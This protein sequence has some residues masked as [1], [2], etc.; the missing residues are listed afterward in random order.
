[1]LMGWD[2]TKETLSKRSGLE[3]GALGSRW[4]PAVAG[5]LS[6]DAKQGSRATGQ[7]KGGAWYLSSS[8][9]FGAVVHLCLWI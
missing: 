5:H 9:S 8:L 7:K 3:H 2:G 1:M 4:G 6:R